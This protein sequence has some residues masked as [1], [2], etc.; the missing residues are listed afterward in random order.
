MRHV[1]YTIIAST[2][3]YL[4][5]IAIMGTWLRMSIS[6]TGSETWRHHFSSVVIAATLV[7]VAWRY[8]QK[9]V[10]RL[11]RI[12][13]YLANI[14]TGWWLVGIISFGLILRIV[15]I[16]IFHALPVS[17]GATYL[18][19]AKQLSSGQGYHMAGTLAYWPPGYPLFLTPWVWFL[20][21]SRLAW[22]L[23][24]LILFCV[25]ALGVWK[26]ATRFLKPGAVKLAVIFI[27]IWP[28]YLT[29][30]ATPEKENLL[31]GIMPWLIYFWLHTL[32]GYKTSGFITGLLLGLMALTQPAFLLLPLVLFI[33]GVL[34]RVNFNN[35][36]VSGIL[37]V[38]GMAIIIGPWTARN[39]DVLG[40]PVIVSTNGGSGLY[41]ANNPL[42]TGGYTDRGEIDLSGFDEVS[43]DRE[44]KRLAIKWIETHPSEF[45]SLALRKQ[46]RFLGDDAGGIYT[47]LRRGLDLDPRLYFVLKT[48]ANIIWVILWF[49]TLSCILYYWKSRELYNDLFIITALVILYFFTLHSV[50]ESDGKYHQVLWPLFP[51]LLLSVIQ[52]QLIKPDEV[53][54]TP[55]SGQ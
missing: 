55:D 13:G 23:P 52:S 17:D 25:T 32:S 46:L 49:V 28:G 27:T 40:I 33:G 31:I 48:L 45:I 22:I 30:V 2:I 41:R 50:F 6:V 14:S 19:L 15:W 8:R 12:C 7:W 36:L 54:W 24:N 5:V 53:K 44:A 11:L 26:L 18:M 34:L 29:L 43:G 39:Y 10:H 9:V 47:T 1:I 20:G 16:L 42:A 51:L 21:E 3:I 35:L 4:A 37:L 38:V